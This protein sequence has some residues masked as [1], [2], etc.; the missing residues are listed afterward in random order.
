M[1]DITNWLDHA[2]TPARTF[3]ITDNGDG[4][5]TLVPVGQVIQQGTPMSAA[6]F[7]NIET[8]IHAANVAAIMAM[9]T[10][11]LAMETADS[12]VVIKDVTLTNTA[13]YPFNNSKM[14]VALND[15]E[16]RHNTKYVVLAEIKNC[17]VED[18]SSVDEL[19]I[20]NAGLVG[21]I[22]ISDKMINGFK[23]ESTG[24]AGDVS[25]RLYIA[26]GM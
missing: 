3:K 10:A 18:G 24:S 2:V 15:K 20:N 23:I 11:R 19:A 16:E 5:Y 13:K 26:G 6:N 7:N 9:N 25:L 1:Y 17:V 12:N 22:V 21:N 4:T 8:G 14:T